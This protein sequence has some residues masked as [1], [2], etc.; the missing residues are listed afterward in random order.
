[1]R[2]RDAANANGIGIP[3]REDEEGLFQAGRLIGRPIVILV[4]SWPGGQVG[5]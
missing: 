5:R 4:T 1:M 3:P 2:P